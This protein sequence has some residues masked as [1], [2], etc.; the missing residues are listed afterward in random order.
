[1]LFDRI[2]Y[3]LDLA[4]E[5]FFSFRKVP[6]GGSTFQMFRNSRVGSVLQNILHFI[7]AATFKS[8]AVACTDFFFHLHLRLVIQYSMNS[9]NIISMLAG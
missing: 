1:M 8:A 3:V 4:Q 7:S 2:N 5:C 9:S 6:A